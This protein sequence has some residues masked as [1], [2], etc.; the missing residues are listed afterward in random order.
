M[1][2]TCNAAS[3]ASVSSA[4]AWGRAPPGSALGSSCLYSDLAGQCGEQRVC[5][6][7]DSG[8]PV[9]WDAQCGEPHGSEQY[10]G[11]IRHNIQLRTGEQ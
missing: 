1:S 8:K 11:A 4:S 9:E 2:W 3:S 6:Q 10:D 7:C 5:V